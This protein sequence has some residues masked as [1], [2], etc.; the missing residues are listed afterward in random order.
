MKHLFLLIIF[1]ATIVFSCSA[2]RELP[3]RD[4]KEAREATVYSDCVSSA[5]IGLGLSSILNNSL[6]ERETE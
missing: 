2:T 6:T 3:E 4:K 1:L 5:F